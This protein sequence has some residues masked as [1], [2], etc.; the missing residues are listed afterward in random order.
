MKNLKVFFYM[1]FRRS[2]Y[3]RANN[4]WDIHLTKL[5][6]LMSAILYMKKEIKENKKHVSQIQ[7]EV[8]DLLMIQY[9]NKERAFISKLYLCNYNES[10]YHEAARKLP[11]NDTLMKTI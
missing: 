6:R 1:M 4:I 3:F 10:L 8:C 11:Y 9:G 5:E 2:V 7:R